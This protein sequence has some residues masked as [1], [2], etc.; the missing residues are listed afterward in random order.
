[1]T[2]NRIKS[3]VL[4]QIEIRSLFGSFERIVS[5][6]FIVE[7]THL[8]SRFFCV[9]WRCSKSSMLQRRKSSFG[10]RLTLS[11]PPLLLLVFLGCSTRLD[12]FLPGNLHF[13][14]QKSRNIVRGSKSL[15]LIYFFIY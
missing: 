5:V 8:E 6:T 7:L 9:V 15:K 10:H 3:V 1:M 11:L 13:Q 12:S 14:G 4:L 2:G